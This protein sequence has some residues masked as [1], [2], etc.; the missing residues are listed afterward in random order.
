MPTMRDM[1]LCVLSK[2]LAQ[3]VDHRAQ[4]G[5]RGQVL[6]ETIQECRV[7]SP[8]LHCGV[9][10]GRSG[11]ECRLLDYPTLLETGPLGPQARARVRRQ[12]ASFGLLDRFLNLQHLFE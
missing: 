11:Y 7:V 10:L 6:L 8:C 1:R 5:A 4:I 2:R 9:P 12:T 3:V